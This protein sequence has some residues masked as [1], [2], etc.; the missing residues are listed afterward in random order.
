ATRFYWPGHAWARGSYACWKVG[1]YTTLAGSEF[2]PVGRL[3][4]AG[5]HTSLDYQG[6]MNGAAE[7][8]R[9]VAQLLHRQLRS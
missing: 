6:Y 7:T 4:F 3:F 8:G 1:Q 2:A 9:R 5:E